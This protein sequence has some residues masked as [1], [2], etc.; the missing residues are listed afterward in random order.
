[1]RSRRTVG[2]LPMNESIMG[3]TWRVCRHDG[4]RPFFRG[5]LLAVVALLIQ[6]IQRHFQQWQLAGLQ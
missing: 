3:R 4:K 2:V 1:M 6:D 5:G